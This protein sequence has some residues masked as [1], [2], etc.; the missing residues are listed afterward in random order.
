MYQDQEGKISHP[1]SE[2]LILPIAGPPTIPPV[3]LPKAVIPEP[4]VV[5]FQASSIYE[6]FKATKEWCQASATVVPSIRKQSLTADVDSLN[7]TAHI[8]VEKEI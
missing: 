1:I 3:D 4:H 8:F 2:G 7:S 6:T 5:S